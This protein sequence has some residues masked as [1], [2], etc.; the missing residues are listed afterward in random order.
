MHNFMKEYE[1]IKIFNGDKIKDMN[2]SDIEAIVYRIKILEHLYLQGMEYIGIEYF[3]KN[4][5]IGRSY[6]CSPTDDRLLDAISKGVPMEYTI[7]GGG[8]IESMEKMERQLHIEYNVAKNK[9]FFNRAIANGGKKNKNDTG[10]SIDRYNELKKLVVEPVLAFNEN[11][12]NPYIP[13]DDRYFNESELKEMG[14]QSEFIPRFENPRTLNSIEK[15]QV[16]EDV[17]TAH[18]KNIRNRIS[19][20][21][22]ATGCNYILIMN[23]YDENTGILVDG[24]CTLEASQPKTLN[25]LNVKTL[26]IPKSFIDKHNITFRDQKAISDMLNPNPPIVKKPMTYRDMIKRLVDE[27]RE[28]GTPIG[29][30][31]QKYFFHHIQGFAKSSITKAIK[32]A[33][34][35]FDS[36]S[37]AITYKNY[38]LVE[39]LPILQE[40]M[41]TVI[42]SKNYGNGFNNKHNSISIPFSVGNALRTY[43]NIYDAILEGYTN[44]HLLPWIPSEKWDRAYTKSVEPVLEKCD[45]LCEMMEPQTIWKDKENGIHE[46]D[47][48]NKVLKKKP[49]I[50]IHLMDKE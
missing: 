12:K 18:I 34:G 8:D 9:K 24:N 31:D 35:E 3:K 50:I 45:L 44:I 43:E 27:R 32:K 26:T 17:P 4:F 11:L 30:D 15:H 48:Q 20:K 22:D 38:S 10:I 39:N 23:M 5:D 25:I 36:G 19:D 46:T 7:E 28:Y 21:G 1:C 47:S 6:L 14:L 16:R 49:K 33:K 41:E 37:K 2:H 42:I 40:K 13:K 29:T